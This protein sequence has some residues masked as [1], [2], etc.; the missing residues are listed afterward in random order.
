MGTKSVE[1]ILAELVLSVGNLSEKIENLN[2]ENLRQ[3]SKFDKIEPK[4]S[5]LSSGMKWVAFIATT[6]LSTAI[7]AVVLIVKY[8]G[9]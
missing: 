3:W 1:V 6:A 8:S 4:L 2:G 9:F 7:G 5:G